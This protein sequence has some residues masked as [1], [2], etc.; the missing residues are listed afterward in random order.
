MEMGDEWC[1]QGSMLG[2]VLFNV[3]IND[4]DSR[5]KCTLTMY[6]YNTKLSSVFNTFDG[7]GAI[8]RDLEKF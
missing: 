4:K 6:A 8:Q 7:W 1:P 3:F 2:P 5:I